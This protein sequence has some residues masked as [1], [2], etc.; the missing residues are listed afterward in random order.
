[1][2]FSVFF[3]CRISVPSRIEG[4]LQTYNEYAGVNG[5]VIIG[6]YIECT[7]SGT[8]DSCLKKAFF[9]LNF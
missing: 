5:H 3:G 8:S 6:E 4:Q 7:Q 9:F 2:C 1:M